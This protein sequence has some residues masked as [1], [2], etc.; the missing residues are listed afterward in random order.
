MLATW[1][2]LVAAALEAARQQQQIDEPIPQVYAND[3][4]AIWPGTRRD[5]EVPFKGRKSLITQLELA[6]GGQAGER[7]TVLLY[8]QRRTGKTSMLLQLPRRLGSQIVPVFVDL[9][10]G[11]FGA[12]DAAGLLSGLADTVADEALAKRNVNLPRLNR[13]G[14]GQRPVSGLG[15]VADRS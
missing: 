1:S 3:G 2:Q 11:K 6:L 8:G 7:S 9:Q 10:A 12:K 15:C 13:R 5:E 14:V 4:K